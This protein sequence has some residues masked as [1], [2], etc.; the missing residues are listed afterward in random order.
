MDM[1]CFVG[2]CSC[3]RTEFYYIEYVM[4]V[5]AGAGGVSRAVELAVQLGLNGLAV[6]GASTVLD[7]NNERAKKTTPRARGG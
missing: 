1:W 3:S 5:D 6:Y 4:P 7:L 2:H